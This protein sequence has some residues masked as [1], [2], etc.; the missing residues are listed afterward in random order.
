MMLFCTQG[1]AQNVRWPCQPIILLIGH[2]EGPTEVQL[3]SLCIAVKLFFRLQRKLID[4]LT[5]P[6]M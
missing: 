6:M 3:N 5:S 1:S 4:S 2:F